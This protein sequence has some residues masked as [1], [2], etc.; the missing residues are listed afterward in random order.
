MGC[1]HFTSALGF[2]SCGYIGCEL[3]GVAARDAEG[4]PFAG[5]R[6]GEMLG[7]ENDLADVVRVV[8]DLPVDRLHHRM[9]FGADRDGALQVRVG[10]RV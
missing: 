4:I 1:T 2:L 7:G 10:Q 3:G 9:R 6:G 5:F 8:R